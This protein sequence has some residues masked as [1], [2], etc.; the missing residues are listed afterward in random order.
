MPCNGGNSSYEK[1]LEIGTLRQTRDYLTRLLC[2]TCST[3]LDNLSEEVSRWYDLHRVEDRR[4]EQEAE[5]RALSE[6]AK[7]RTR[8]E[9]ESVR[10]RLRDQLTPD[11]CRAVGLNPKPQVGEC[12]DYQERNRHLPG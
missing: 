3:N 1:S 10:E 12:D 7:E 5:T 8:E 11:E 9:I 2:A 4:R 6:E